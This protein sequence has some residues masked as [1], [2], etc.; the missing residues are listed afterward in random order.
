LNILQN[1]TTP[2]NPEP[3]RNKVAG[4]GTDISPAGYTLPG[5][6][7][8]NSAKKNNNDKPFIIFTLLK[9]V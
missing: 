1:P 5:E 8:N 2:I 3:S 6:T 7:R 9:I 4:S